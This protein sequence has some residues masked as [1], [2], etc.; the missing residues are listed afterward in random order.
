MQVLDPN[1][2]L[3]SVSHEQSLKVKYLRLN[4]NIAAHNCGAVMAS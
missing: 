2:T 1:K 4:I 3:L